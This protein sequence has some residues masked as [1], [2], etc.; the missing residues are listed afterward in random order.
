MRR[1]IMF[2]RLVF[3]MGHD[4]DKTLLQRVSD[5]GFSTPTAVG[6]FLQKIITSY[7][8]R[9]R[10]TANKDLEMERFKKL[11]A[12]EKLLLDNQIKKYCGKKQVILMPT[13]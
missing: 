10:L 6:V 11:V 2:R 4:E 1:L 8:E 5:M 12:S 7:K 3:N 9:M 13:N